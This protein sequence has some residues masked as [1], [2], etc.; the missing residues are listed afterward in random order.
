MEDQYANKLRFPLQTLWS[1]NRCGLTSLARLMSNY[2][3]KICQNQQVKYIIT[4]F[5]FL[6]Q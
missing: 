5:Y 1:I 6:M 2:H 4:N 3:W